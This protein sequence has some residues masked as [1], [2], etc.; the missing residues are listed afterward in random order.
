MA[1]GIPLWPGPDAG[2]RPPP[3]LG[4]RQGHPLRRSSGPCG[5]LRA[6]RPTRARP[7]RR[8]GRLG[9][10]RRPSAQGASLD[11][12]RSHDLLRSC[13]RNG[14]SS[15]AVD[16]ARIATCRGHATLAKR[17]RTQW[18][19]RIVRVLVLTRLPLRP[20]FLPR[21]LSRACRRAGRHGRSAP[22][23]AGMLANVGARG[24]KGPPF[25]G[26]Q[27][28]A[29]PARALPSR[30]FGQAGV[31]R[32]FEEGTSGRR[33]RSRRS[34]SVPARRARPRSCPRSAGPGGRKRPAPARPAGA[35]PRRG[36]P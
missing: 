8:S 5:G 34:P 1:P 2:L 10:F 12:G 9:A 36:R 25:L 20:A 32:P 28:A 6:R 19:S 7:S 15:R 21:R 26:G 18:P 27:R 4:P 23:L 3:A 22:R 31:R 17:P 30:L 33:P 14:R 35:V 11:A 29:L 24:R 16:P 13:H